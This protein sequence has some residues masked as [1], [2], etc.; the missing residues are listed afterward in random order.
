LFLSFTGNRWWSRFDAVWR[1]LST[2]AGSWIGEEPI[3]AAMLE[4]LNTTKEN[5]DV[6]L[7][8]IYL[9][10]IW[11]KAV[12]FSVLEEKKKSIIEKQADT[13]SSKN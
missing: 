5:T 2:V 1:G 9:A 3:Q 11:M 6:V 10:N 8:D 13:S 7:V 4:V 12:Y